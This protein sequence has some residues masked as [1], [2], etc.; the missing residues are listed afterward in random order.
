MSG[1]WLTFARKSQSLF[2]ALSL[3]D[4]WPERN[5]GWQRRSDDVGQPA[6]MFTR[7]IKSIKPRFGIKCGDERTER[8]TKRD[9]LL[10]CRHWICPRGGTN[11]KKKI[12]KSIYAFYMTLSSRHLPDPK[13]VPIEKKQKI[14]AHLS[15]T[16]VKNIPYSPAA[17]PTPSPNHHTGTASLPRVGRVWVH[18]WS[19]I[20]H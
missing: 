3:V 11:S 19:E 4:S 6:G 14:S 13:V 7:R 20:L 16:R 12:E 15:T 10:W 9:I 1:S 5:V 17:H 8:R 2:K 18:I